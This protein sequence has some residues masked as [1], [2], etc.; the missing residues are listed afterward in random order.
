[1][2]RQTILRRFPFALLALVLAA[3]GDGGGSSSSTTPTTTATA[4]ASSTPTLTSTFT[5]TNT[6]VPPSAT[7]SSTASPTATNIPAAELHFTQPQDQQLSRA[8][9]VNVALALPVAITPESL[10]A[11]VDGVAVAMTISGSSAN[12]TAGGL[13]AGSH[14]LAAQVRALGGQLLQTEVV[15]ETIVLDRPDECEVL[16]NAE[17]LLPYPSS[18]F[19]EQGDTDTGLRLKLP[20][21]GMPAQ[22]GRPIPVAPYNLGDGFSPTVQILMH[23]PGGVDL[24]RSNAARLLAA[25]RSYGTRSLDADS[26]TVLLDANTGERILHFVENDAR[27]T[28]DARRP[29]FLRPGKSLTPGHRYIVA[30]RNL[31]HSDGSVVVAEAPFAAL[32]DERPTDI[33]AIESRRDNFRGIFDTL[34]AAGV[35]RSSLILA[36]DFTVASDDGLTGSMLIMRQHAFEWLAATQDRTFTVERVAENDCSQP[37]A[38]VWRT[39]EGT[40][41]VPL[42]LKGDPVTSPA[43]PALLNTEADGSLNGR[44]IPNGFT[45]PPFTIAIPC[46]ALADGGTPLLPLVLGHGLFGDGRGFVRSVGDATDGEIDLIAGA[47]DWRGLSTPDV[48]GEDLSRT[49]IGRVILQLQNFSAMPDRLRQGQLNTLVLA[50]M[51]RTG[52]FN[53]DDA[54]KLPSGVGAFAAGEPQGF[55][56][57]G[58][59]GGIMGLMFAALSPDVTNV[60]VVVPAMNFS[61]LLQR[62][63]PFIAFEGVLELSGIRDPIKQA[64]LLGLLHELWVRGESAGYATHI[65]SNP[66]PDTNIKNVLMTAAFLDQQVSNQGTEVAART[67]GLPSLVGSLQSDLAQI[68]DLPGPLSSA[69][70]MYD[71]GAFDLDNPAHRPFIPPLANRQAEPNRC[72]PHGRQAAI[73]A[74]QAQIAAFLRPGGQVE[75][76]C[77]GICDAEGPDEL[78]NG[79]SERCKPVDDPAPTP[80]PTNDTLSFDFHDGA[81]GW[82]TGFADYPIADQPIY[83][84]ESGIRTLPSELTDP[85]TGYFVKGN[86]HSDDLFMFLRRRLGPEDGIVPNQRYRLH[87]TLTFASNAQSGCVGVGGAPGESVYLKVGGSDLPPVVLNDL[88]QARL[89]LDKG[90][91]AQGGTAAS[92]IGDIANGIACDPGLTFY[93]PLTR[94]GVHESAT[95]ASDGALWL[96]VGTDSGFEATTALYYQKIEVRLEA[97]PS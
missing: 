91:Q 5:P 66:L 26:P 45:N 41:Q 87:Y 67:L 42:F 69:L 4:T 84:L 33:N 97:L 94:T 28:D 34:F 50:R 16:N 43:V 30:V 15:F 62:A 27:A 56:L 8:G 14:R 95:A 29:L 96:L 23:F 39:I 59:L 24:E 71:V 22:N 93:V 21:A 86:N 70:V 68:P 61:I 9:D 51:M 46:S 7:P 37:S 83:E 32:R 89:N 57:G 80:T 54:F 85:G 52:A 73:P 3:C 31:V 11:T 75:N 2:R 13:A 64:L 49:F 72:D 58:S 63:T 17:C 18:R 92:T 81:Q 25:T 35:A 77:N 10:A 47:T 78:P 65:T 53:V 79:D 74:A 40:Y 38:V 1:M 82:E 20:Q 36:F 60:D 44:P 19:L 6:T 88:G 76:F 55:Y 90:N 48:A 12:G